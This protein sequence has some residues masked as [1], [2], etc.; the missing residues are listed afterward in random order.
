VPKEV[1]KVTLILHVQG[2]N[3]TSKESFTFTN[4]L[5]VDPKEANIN[6]VVYHRYGDDDNFVD[7]RPDLI[8]MRSIKTIYKDKPDGGPSVTGPLPKIASGPPEPAA[9]LER[10]EPGGS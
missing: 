7:I 1:D 6:G 10:G 2:E 5:D 9:A 8:V 3:F 4:M